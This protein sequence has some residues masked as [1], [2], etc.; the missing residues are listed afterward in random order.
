MATYDVEVR[1]E[2]S[3]RRQIRALDRQFA[4]AMQDEAITIKKQLCILWNELL[5]VRRTSPIAIN[6]LTKD[7]SELKI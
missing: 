1:D 4:E 7:S 2:K 5:K 6:K 3:L